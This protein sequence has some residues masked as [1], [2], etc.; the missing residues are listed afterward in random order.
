MIK[1]ITLAV[2]LTFASCAVKQFK[3]DYLPGMD[4]FNFDMYSG[5]LPVLSSDTRFLHYIFVTS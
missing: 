2:L 1:I 4:Y 3:V 5:Y